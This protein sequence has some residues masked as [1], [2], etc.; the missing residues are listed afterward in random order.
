MLTN[1]KQ[2]PFAF[3]VKNSTDNFY[4]WSGYIK[5]SIPQPLYA[6]RSI[7]QPA[8]VTEYGEPV[9]Q[10][11][12][13][14]LDRA[15]GTML[16]KRL[17]L[18]RFAGLA[19]LIL[20]ARNA[21]AE[22]VGVSQRGTPSKQGA[23]QPAQKDK[24]ATMTGCVDQQE[25]KYVLVDDHS[26]VRIADLEADGFPTEGFAKHVGHKVTV[27][28]IRSTNGTTQVFKVHTVETVSETCAPQPQQGKQ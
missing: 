17:A 19:V 3:R 27:R 25:D 26:L 7:T 10:L 15:V 9:C 5:R 16:I 12:P 24:A 1:V 21:V 28:G 6:V 13:E 18:A 8:V 11:A 2:E 4:E 14:L 22:P 20:L 23:A